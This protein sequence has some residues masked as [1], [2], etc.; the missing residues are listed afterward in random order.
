MYCYRFY[1]LVS[2]R[3]FRV[4]DRVEVVES[5]DS[6]A[7]AIGTI[8]SLMKKKAGSKGAIIVDLGEGIIESFE[9]QS[10]SIVSDAVGPIGILDENRRRTITHKWTEMID[11]DLESPE[12]Y[13]RA[14]TMARQ[15]AKV[16]CQRKCFE[17]SM[18]KS[19]ESSTLGFDFRN[20][21]SRD[22]DVYAFAA[23]IYAVMMRQGF[24]TSIDSNR[25]ESS[26]MKRFRALLMKNH[27]LDDNE[28]VKRHHSSF[29]SMFSFGNISSPPRPTR[30][31]RL[32]SSPSTRSLL[33]ILSDNDKNEQAL[34]DNGTV[35]FYRVIGKCLRTDPNAR[36]KSGRCYNL[37]SDCI[38][39][40]HFDAA[41]K[42]TS[43]DKN[44]KLHSV[45][46]KGSVRVQIFFGGGF[47]LSL[48]LSLSLS[49]THTHSQQQQQNIGGIGTGKYYQNVLRKDSSSI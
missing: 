15:H 33:D 32:S 1:R 10:L 26:G 29:K 20:T 43:F 2:K 23:T 36:P 17:K 45:E 28:Q 41:K 6:N 42:M 25:S 9:P 18:F 13:S 27:S 44:I 7:G 21:L 40:W 38:E 11:R 47:S 4:G 5:L 48:S 34:C 35:Q 19:P 24:D 46:K 3:P 12:A 37:V 49:S 8:L 16:L 31:Y 30:R 22:A 39:M 14:N